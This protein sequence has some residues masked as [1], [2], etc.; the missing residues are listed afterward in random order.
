MTKAFDALDHHLSKPP[1]FVEALEKLS[2]LKFDF[3]EEIQERDDA[4]D[5]LEQQKDAETERA[6]T[7]E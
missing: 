6:N 5:L 4:N 2:L 1:Y 3:N 7:S